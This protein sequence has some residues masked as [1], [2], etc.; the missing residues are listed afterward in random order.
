MPIITMKQ[1]LEA[2]V[3]FGHQ[4]R[5]WNPKMK[6]YIYGARNGIYII[7][8]QQTVTMFD[9]AYQFLVRTVSQGE[10]VLFVGT[11]RQAQAV[12][13][14]E[15]R[16]AGMPFVNHR[17]LGGTLTNFK[18]IRSSI[19]H[20]KKIE[21]MAADGKLDLLPKKE[22][23]R[24]QREYNK[25]ERNVGGIKEMGRLPGALFVIDPNHE[26]IAVREARKAGIPVVGIVD[27]NCDPDLIDHIIPGN[28]DAIKAIKLFMGKVADACLEGKEMHQKLL[29]VEPEIAASAS[30]VDAVADGKRPKVERLKDL[31]AEEMGE[32]AEEEGEEELEDEVMEEDEEEVDEQD[33][34]D[35]NEPR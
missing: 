9:A 2:G 27:T 31:V 16:R 1:L 17:W 7:D 25:L 12:V 19:E 8:L 13:E 33:E 24:I 21:E 26:E 14:E 28:D 35:D 6:P 22:V 18:V 32:E 4:T 5:R 15:A 30:L 34:N 10:E 29:R 20:L 3:H 23:L 11:K